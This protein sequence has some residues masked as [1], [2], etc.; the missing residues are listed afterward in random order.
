MMGGGMMSGMSWFMG[1]ISVLILIVLV[2][3][4]IALLKYLFR[5]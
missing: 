2:L 5:R 1:T 4:I 3:A